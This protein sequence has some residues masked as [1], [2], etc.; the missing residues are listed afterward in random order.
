M[1]LAWM[2]ALSPVVVPIPGCS[3]PE[4]ILDSVA[5]AGLSLSANEVERLSAS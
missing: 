4:T 2:L 5:A 1:T 3:R